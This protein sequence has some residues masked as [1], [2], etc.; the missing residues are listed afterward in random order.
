M[1][2]IVAGPLRR[3]RGI[4]MAE[5]DPEKV[6]RA[7]RTLDVAGHYSRPDVFRFEVRKLSGE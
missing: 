7:R 3:E 1:G 6:T 5:C 4:L 2:K